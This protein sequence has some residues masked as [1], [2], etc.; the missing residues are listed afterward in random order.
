MCHRAGF[1]SQSAGITMNPNLQSADIQG[2]QLFD[3][4][5]FSLKIDQALGQKEKEEK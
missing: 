5:V 4:M 2:R 1:R 3:D